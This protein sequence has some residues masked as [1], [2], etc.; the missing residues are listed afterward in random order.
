VD[1]SV[2]SQVQRFVE[3][4]IS[5]FGKIDILVNSAGVVTR[6]SFIEASEE[7]WDRTFNVNLKGLFLC[8]QAVARQM[9]RQE[10][11]KI[12]SIAS[13]AG[14]G[15]TG[16]LSPGY[17]ASKAGV[18][19]LTRAMAVELAAHNI[20]VNAIGPGLVE[21]PMTEE[22]TTDP[23]RRRDL[24]RRIPLK[25]LGSPHDIVGTSIFLAS[26]ESD[27]ITGQTIFIDGGSLS[28]YR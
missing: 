23:D 24:I 18:I 26:T 15:H 17:M 16:G 8:S 20:N 2:K 6:E 22:V 14:R 25:R 4:S 19:M 9:I 27:Y 13:A 21:T 10:G 28:I 1:V 11:G 7:N 3:S 5:G 12:I